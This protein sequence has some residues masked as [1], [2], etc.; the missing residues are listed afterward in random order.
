M[1]E[2]QADR[3]NG[4]GWRTTIAAEIG[5]P[6]FLESLTLSLP[7]LFYLLSYCFPTPRGQEQCQI[8]ELVILNSWS[9]Q[10]VSWAN[11]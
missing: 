6:D 9:F 7:L 3:E 8:F 2:D 1:Q 11:S 4:E 10:L 5:S